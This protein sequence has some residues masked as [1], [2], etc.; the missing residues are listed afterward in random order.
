M[1]PIRYKGHIVAVA[2]PGGIHLRGSVAE[3]EIVGPELWAVLEGVPGLPL[4]LTGNPADGL[5]G[6]LELDPT[7]AILGVVPDPVALVAERLCVSRPRVPRPIGA[8]RIGEAVYPGIHAAPGVVAWGAGYIAA[9][10]IVAEGPG[11][12]WDLIVGPAS[13]DW[14]VG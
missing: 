2:S 5:V 10:P 8:V 13:A 7:W 1:T 12:G 14:T 11:T 3:T 6:E 9:A 4:E